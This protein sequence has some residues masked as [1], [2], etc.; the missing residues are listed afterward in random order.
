MI[1][2]VKYLAPFNFLLGKKTSSISIPDKDSVS[3]WELLEH[4][5]KN[6]PRFTEKVIMK[7]D[8]VFNKLS[9]LVEGVVCDLDA[10]VPDDANVVLMSPVCG[11]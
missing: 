9:V 11:G 6:E 4:I 2:Q 3:V 7:K 1:L 5:A 8:I 10:V